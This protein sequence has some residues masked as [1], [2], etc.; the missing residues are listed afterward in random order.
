MDSTPVE[1]AMSALKGEV[2]KL[3]LL[4]ENFC[5]HQATCTQTQYLSRQGLAFSYHQ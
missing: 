3:L 1:V 4:G 5:A 2:K